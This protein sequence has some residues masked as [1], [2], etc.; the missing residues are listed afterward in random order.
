MD[1]EAVV[2][3][4]KNGRLEIIR[5]LYQ[6]GADI[7]TGYGCPVIYASTEGHTETVRL[8]HNLGANLSVADNLPIKRAICRRH[9]ETVRYLLKRGVNPNAVYLGGNTLLHLALRGG[10][11]D[12]GEL[13]LDKG[14]MQTGQTLT[15]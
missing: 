5:Y 14:R 6:Q 13:L 11:F 9:T 3:A 1:N 4:A 2:V 15:V 8:L 12:I 7:Q 10:V